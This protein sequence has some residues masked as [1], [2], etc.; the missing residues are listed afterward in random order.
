MAILGGREHGLPV[1]ISEVFPETAVSRS[2]G[3]NAGDIIRAVNGEAFAD[4]GHEEA[5]KYL[6]SLRG[7]IFIT[8]T[9]FHYVALSA[10]KFL[11]DFS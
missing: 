9:L 5:V 1:M 10:L 7:K 3:I 6:S 11:F 2:K 4:I 8:T